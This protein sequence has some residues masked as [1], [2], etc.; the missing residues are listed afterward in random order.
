MASPRSKFATLY[1]KIV[2]GC[3]GPETL[4]QNENGCWPWAK[5]IDRYGYGTVNIYLVALGKTVKR[6]VHRALVESL[7]GRKLDED[8]ETIEHSKTCVR[9]CANPDHLS[10]LSRPDNTK[11]ARGGVVFPKPLPDPVENWEAVYVRTYQPDEPCP[12]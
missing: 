3:A 12:F 4:G 10:L 1:A 2:A 8:E 5:L 11:R 9:R 6:K 7:I